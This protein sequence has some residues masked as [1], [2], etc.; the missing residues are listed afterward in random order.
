MISPP[1]ICDID[2]LVTSGKVT[3]KNP[4]EATGGFDK[5]VSNY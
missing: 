3:N 2:N 1:Y 5:N 4:P